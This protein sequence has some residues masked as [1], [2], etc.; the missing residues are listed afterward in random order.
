MNLF[1]R[2]KVVKIPGN[3]TIFFTF[4]QVSRNWHLKPN[5]KKYMQMPFLKHLFFLKLHRAQRAKFRKYAQILACI[6]MTLVSIAVAETMCT[7]LLGI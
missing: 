5:L 7:D 6:P 2:T 3:F 4:I 1:K